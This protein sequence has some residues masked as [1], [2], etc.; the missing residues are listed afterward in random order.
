M[1]RNCSKALGILQAYLRNSVYNVSM[2]SFANAVEFFERCYRTPDVETGKSMITFR[3]FIY[4]EFKIASHALF[5][6]QSLHNSMTL[7]YQSCH[8]G[9]TLLN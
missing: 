1:A 9:I 8:V 3:C 4:N 7:C 6:C 5:N 2:S